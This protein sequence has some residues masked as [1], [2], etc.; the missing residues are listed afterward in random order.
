MGAFS[1]VVTRRSLV[2]RTECIAN[3]AALFN[4]S[5]R[6]VLTERNKIRVIHI[7]RKINPFDVKSTLY[8]SLWFDIAV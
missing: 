1:A 5:Y 2:H 3:S 7:G 6:V 8:F 4:L